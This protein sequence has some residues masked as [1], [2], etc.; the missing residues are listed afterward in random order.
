MIEMTDLTG[1]GA[2]LQAR[3]E[4][5]KGIE[6]RLFRGMWITVAVA[7][8]ASL[9]LAPW[10]VT[11]GLLLGGVL[12]LVNHHWLRTAITAAF[13]AHSLA[14]GAKPKLRI[15]RYIVRYFLLGAI[16]AFAYA[17][18][19]ISLV[20]ALLGLCSFVVAT[21]AE[22]LMQVYFAIRYGEEN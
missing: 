12:S 8:L 4:D 18:D 5:L 19:L 14:R 16:I 1:R 17:L 2:S 7:V 3:D 21:F 22:A 10:R 9:A 11:T 13:D 15:A 6:R 20:A